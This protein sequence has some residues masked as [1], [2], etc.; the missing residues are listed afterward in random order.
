MYR[1]VFGSLKKGENVSEKPEEK[2]FEIWCVWFSLAGWTVRIT[3]LT[4]LY[5]VQIGLLLAGQFL[6]THPTCV[7][8]AFS[9]SAFQSWLQAQKGIS[10]H[11]KHGGYK[12]SLWESGIPGS[13]HFSV[14]KVMCL[15]LY[16]SF[17]AP[18]KESKYN[19]PTLKLRTHMFPPIVPSAWAPPSPAFCVL[20]M[21]EHDM[22]IPLYFSVKGRMEW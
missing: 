7:L 13:Y 6:L 21:A 1:E 15:Y 10:Y 12:G 20:V 18:G 3:S 9:S 11:N 14:N 19:C 4:L 22:G 16:S 8:F 17:H 2:K 5:G